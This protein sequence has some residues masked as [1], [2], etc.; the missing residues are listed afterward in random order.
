MP[1]PEFLA[2]LVRRTGCGLLV[3]VNNVAVAACNLGSSAR[4]YLDA[5]PHSAIG[6][7]HIAGHSPDPTPPAG[8]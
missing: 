1:E 3:D 4:D 2:E 6:E 8:C 5:L 7:I